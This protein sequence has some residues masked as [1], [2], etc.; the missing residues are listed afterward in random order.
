M[1]FPSVQFIFFFLPIV[2]LVY[3]SIKVNRYQNLFL[4]TASVFFYF[5][6]EAWHIIFLLVTVIFA[7]F[8]GI[9]IQRASNG[10]KKTLLIFAVSFNLLLLVAVKYLGFIVE[11]IFGILQLLAVEL[12]VPKI[13]QHLP[14]GISFF[15]FHAISY[16]V[17]IFRGKI[18][19]EERLS[20]VSLYFF[21]FPHQ[22]AGPIVR[23]SHF[24]VNADSKQVSNDDFYIGIERFIQGL[25]KKVLVSNL[26]AM[27]ADRV[28][29]LPGANLSGTVAWIGIISYTIQIYFDFSGYSDMAIG[30]ARMFGFHFHE[31]FNFPYAARSITDFWRRWHISLSSWFRDYLYIPLGGNRVSRTKNYF[32]LAI[33]F[34]LC[35]LWHGASWTFVVWGLWH[36]LFLILER[37]GIEEKISYFRP[38][39]HIWTLLIVVI[40]WVFFRADSI[41]HAI[42]FLNAMFQFPKSGE[43]Y[44]AVATTSN[45]IG[46]G[47]GIL[48]ASGKL[49][50]FLKTKAKK[51][52]GLYESILLIL[53]I[54]SI[55]RLAGATFNPFIYFRF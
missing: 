31:N 46:I 9:R 21:L 12:T 2:L 33:V 44:Q 24:E 40:G 27:S 17:D 39:S 11:I 54:V 7:Y 34:L 52:P 6:G 38:I 4:L 42:S 49:G 28:F 51:I 23:Y 15:V 53:F 1:L 5:W 30:L 13:H 16:L 45:F 20:V 37:L 43:P 19:A 8:L 48:F 25:I 29:E 10:R 22:I 3:W 36:G 14:L 55:V 47:L 18:K 41:H 35:G 32:N 26:V 50:Y